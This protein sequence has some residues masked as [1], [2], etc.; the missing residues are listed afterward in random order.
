MFRDALEFGRRFVTY[1]FDLLTLFEGELV[2]GLIGGKA[3][4]TGPARHA[5]AGTI[6]GIM[7]APVGVGGR[8]FGNH[9]NNST[10]AGYGNSPRYF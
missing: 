10:H 9:G 8:E 4:F 6:A 2:L 1:L 5:V 3:A 7:S